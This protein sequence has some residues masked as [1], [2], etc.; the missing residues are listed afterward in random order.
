MGTKIDWDAVLLGEVDWDAVLPNHQWKRRGARSWEHVMPP[1]QRQ[2]EILP[3]DVGGSCAVHSFSET[4]TGLLR[5]GLPPS[6]I[7]VDL[8]RLLH[9][10]AAKGILTDEGSALAWIDLLA[11]SYGIPL[12]VRLLN[13]T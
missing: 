2:L 9:L 7:K 1:P 10:S 8:P 6:S 12:M 4:L 3:K 11:K 13:A 5:I